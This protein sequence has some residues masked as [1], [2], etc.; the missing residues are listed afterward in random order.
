MK[1]TGGNAWMFGT[2]GSHFSGTAI[3]A[4]VIGTLKFTSNARIISMY[5]TGGNDTG[6]ASF[7][8]YQASSTTA[9]LYNSGNVATVTTPDRTS[10]LAGVY[11]ARFDGAHG[12]PRF[13]STDGTPG[14][15]APTLSL[16][17][18]DFSDVNGLDDPF[19]VCEWAII[20]HALTLAEWALWSSYT[21][22]RYGLPA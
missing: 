16:D 19:D 9:T 18:F 13:G 17:N 10:G 22:A 20:N 15:S 1:S 3:T 21:L 14:V 5:A 7:T 11:S 2:L 8:L 12:T 4:I 6:V